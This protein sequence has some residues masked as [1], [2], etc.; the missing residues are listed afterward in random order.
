VSGGSLN[1]FVNPSQTILLR[2]KSSRK[3]PDGKFVK[4]YALADGS[5]QL[6]SSP[7]DDFTTMEK[8]FGFLVQPAKK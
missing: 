2:E 5:V 1:S 4:I 7:D 6:V 8:K 3:S